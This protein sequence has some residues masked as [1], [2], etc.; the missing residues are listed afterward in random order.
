MLFPLCPDTNYGANCYS[1]RDIQHFHLHGKSYSDPNFGGFGVKHPQIVTANNF[2]PQKAL[3]YAN[4]RLFE[5]FWALL[6]LS[7]WYVGLSR[8]KKVTPPV[9]FTH[10]RSAATDPKWTKLGRV[11]P[12]PNVIAHTQFHVQCFKAV[13]MAGGRM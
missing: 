1:F 4:P 3:R 6:A 9:Y 7:I 2:N 13:G 5:P 11:G 12:W 10:R 8:N